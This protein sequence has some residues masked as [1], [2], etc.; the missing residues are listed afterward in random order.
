MNKLNYCRLDI[1]AGVFD[2]LENNGP[3]PVTQSINFYNKLLAD[4]NVRDS[5]KY[6]SDKEKLMLLEFRKP[7]AD[8][9][10]IGGRDICI[11][12]ESNNIRLT[13]FMGMHEMLIKFAL[14]D[15]LR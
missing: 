1:Y 6:V 14:L 15:L 9:D 11:V 12:K 3:V 2:G 13:I 4:L 7:L 5:T 10:Q 8:Y